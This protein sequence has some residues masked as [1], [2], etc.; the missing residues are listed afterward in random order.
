MV[1][2]QKYVYSDFDSHLKN[3]INFSFESRKLSLLS[4]GV[5]GTSV[6]LRCDL[7]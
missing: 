4:D 2:L 3:A 7:M 6:E 5:S 1:K